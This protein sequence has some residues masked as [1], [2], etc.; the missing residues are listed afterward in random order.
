MDEKNAGRTVN[1]PFRVTVDVIAGVFLLGLS[2]YVII[3]SYVTLPLG[4]HFN[5]GP[6]YMPM[7][8]GI[9]LGVLALSIVARGR[10]S[11]ALRDLDWPGYKHGVGIVGCCIFAVL[12]LEGLG[13]RLTMFL[14]L[15]F[16]FGVLERLKA[17]L[18]LVLSAGLCLGSYWLFHKLLAVPLPIGELGF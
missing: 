1:K 6:G 10:R 4:T 11:T 9:V 8:L 13:Y 3:Y 5:P 17:W 15:L 14:I 18:T 2:I 16:L 12:A 7:L